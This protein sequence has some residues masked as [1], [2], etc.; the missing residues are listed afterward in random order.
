MPAIASHRV[1]S[2]DVLDNNLMFII[3]FL[4]NC[5]RPFVPVSVKQHY[6]M[7]Y[8][9]SKKASE[10]E[11]SN[12]HYEH[13]YTN[14]FEID[15]NYYVD[16]T[17]LD[18]GCGPRGSLEWADNASRRIGLDPLANKYL[19]LG[20]KHH[21]MEYISSPSE[22]IP[23]SSESCDAVFSFNSLDHVDNLQKTAD[24]ISR[25]TKKG[26]IFLLLVEVNH[27][28][29]VCEPHG[30]TPQIIIELFQDTFKIDRLNLF[31]P[32]IEHSMYESVLDNEIFDDP[33]SSSEI[34][35]FS[36]KFVKS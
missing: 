13:F 11:L 21:N 27:P 3:N 12:V 5:I 35:F 32:T 4:K 33:Y 28:P 10:G 26:G 8:W 20:A 30:L 19:Q 7:K 22:N 2:K 36:V 14:H 31:K 16:K 25:V 15:K 6:E 29:T 17:I 24:E 9:R 1:P 18:I 34:G 23:L